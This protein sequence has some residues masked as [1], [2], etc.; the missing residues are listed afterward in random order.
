MEELNNTPKLSESIWYQIIPH[1]PYQ[2]LKNDKNVCKNNH[3]SNT[4]FNMTD[5][6]FDSKYFFFFKRILNL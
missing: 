1:S 5:L 2:N 4:D 6:S 3:F